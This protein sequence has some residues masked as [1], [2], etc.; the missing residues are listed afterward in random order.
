M[1][2]KRELLRRKEYSTLMCRAPESL[3]RED[4]TIATYLF[5]N[6]DADGDIVKQAVSWA[7]EQ[8]TGTWINV[9]GE[10][11]EVRAKFSAK[12]V[13]IYEVPDYET[14]SMLD[15]NNK[16]NFIVRLA[17]PNVNFLDQIPGL[18]TAVAGNI[19]FSSAIKLL[20]LEFSK[21]FVK[22]FKGPK[23]GIE[24]IRK[25]LG[26]YDRPLLNN[27]IKPCTGITPDAGAELCYQAAVGGTDIIKDDELN[28]ASVTISP[29]KERVKK[30][31]EAIRRADSEKGEKTLYTVNITDRNKKLRENALTA[32][33]AGANALMLNFTVGYSAIRELAEDPEINVPILLHPDTS[34]AIF[35]SPYSGISSPLVLAKLGRLAG[36]DIV[37]YPSPYGKL[38]ILK[39]KEILIANTLLSKFYEIKP[40]FPALGG[41]VHPGLV[42]VTIKDLGID[43]IIGV[44]GAIHGHPM[45]PQAGAMAMRQAIDATL[46]GISL[47]DASREHKE[48]KA[49]IERWG[50]YSPT[51]KGKIYPL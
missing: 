17:F 21:S 16:R 4:Y 51:S 13:G 29:L 31:M 9:P 15:N 49:A 37:M 18:L 44:G 6:V 50:V 38:A 30:Y 26:V 24:G 10:T 11:E 39:S 19:T 7:V 22:T 27:M 43:C 41:G 35:N 12:V 36:A 1:K 3:E 2:E 34:G 48:L 42:P 33:D 32:I 46:K 5:S 23:Y 28:N 20:D 14:N 47:E 25:I 8:T 40:A 45:G